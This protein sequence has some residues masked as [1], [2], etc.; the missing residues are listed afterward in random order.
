MAT[1][2]VNRTMKRKVFVVGV[3]MTKVRNVT[4]EKLDK[5]KRILLDCLVVTYSKCCF[6]VKFIEKLIFMKGAL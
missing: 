6:H 3:G 1:T 5:L 4:T 2:A